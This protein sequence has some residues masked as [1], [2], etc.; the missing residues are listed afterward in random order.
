M[1]D[2]RQP[3]ANVSRPEILYARWDAATIAPWRPGQWSKLGERLHFALH[4]LVAAVAMVD[5]EVDGAERGGLGSIADN[6][7][8][9]VRSEIVDR[10]AASGRARTGYQRI[11]EADDLEAAGRLGEAPAASDPVS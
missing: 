7:W 8:D 1:T 4:D 11:G 5:M 10:V 9:V 3:G 2:E 6:V